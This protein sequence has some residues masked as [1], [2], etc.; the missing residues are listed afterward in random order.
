MFEQSLLRVNDSIRQ[1]ITSTILVYQKHTSKWYAKRRVLEYM[2]LPV[3]FNFTGND[4]G[5][6]F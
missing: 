5:F 6:E 4:S 1:V 2:S 3:T